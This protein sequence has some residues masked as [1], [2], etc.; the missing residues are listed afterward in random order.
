VEVEVEGQIRHRQDRECHACIKHSLIRSA[1]SHHG[2]VSPSSL[3]LACHDHIK[4]CTPSVDNP[5]QDFTATV[6]GAEA[7]T[8]TFS[9]GDNIDLSLPNGA[10]T[11]VITN[12]NFASC[13]SQ[14]KTFTID[15]GEFYET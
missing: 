8:A 1:R 11:I 3:A 4:Y 7:Q 12:P 2:I 14:E 9:A 10:Y 15:C 6:S 13:E 5:A